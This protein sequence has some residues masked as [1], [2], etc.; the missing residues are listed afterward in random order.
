V[1]FDSVRLNGATWSFLDQDVVEREGDL[2]VDRGPVGRVA[3]LHKDVAV[4]AHLLGVVFAMCGWY[5]YA[6][7]S[8]TAA[9]R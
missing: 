7:G 8:G 6:P 3:G 5:Q 2:A 1:R 4:E 9:D